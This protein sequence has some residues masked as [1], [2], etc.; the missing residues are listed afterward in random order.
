MR[1]LGDL[2]HVQRKKALLL[3]G[4]GAL[5]AILSAGGVFGAFSATVSSTG[6]QFATSS[7]LTPPT[8]VRAVLRKSYGGVSSFTGCGIGGCGV[9]DSRQFYVYAQVTDGGS[10]PSGVASVNTTV[11]GSSSAL[12]SA[13]GPWTVDGLTY[14]YRSG[15]LTR[16]AAQLAVG[17]RTLT[18]AATDVA[19]RS[20]TSSPYAFTVETTQP[21][22]SLVTLADAGASTGPNT[23]D[24]AVYDFDSPLD[25]N[26]LF[27][28]WT[29]S[30]PPIVYANTWTGASANVRIDLTSPSKYGGTA[31]DP[32]L[33][34]V[35]HASLPGNPQMNIGTVRIYSD[36]W[37]VHCEARFNG[38]AQLSNSDARATVTFG[39]EITSGQLILPAP[40]TPELETCP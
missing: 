38:T 17:S 27:G 29:T 31:S 2:A 33:M 11:G 30:G 34:R 12:T 24:T 26:S 23:G 18:I 40:V 19:G 21:V 4:F 25:P 28:N 35:Y 3:L 36:D 1:K 37:Y 15:F 8:T 16:S 13:G 39:S 22:P 20:S 10:P 7:D 32:I 14:N 5:V 6:N 9:L